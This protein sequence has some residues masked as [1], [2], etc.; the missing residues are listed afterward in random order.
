MI[1]RK[2]LCQYLNISCSL[3][4]PEFTAEKNVT[5]EPSNG[6]QII[7]TARSRGARLD[8]KIW[9]QVGQVDGLPN[10]SSWRVELWSRVKVAWEQEP[11]ITQAA[12]WVNKG[13]CK[14]HRQPTK[15]FEIFVKRMKVLEEPSKAEWERK[16]KQQSSH[17]FQGKFFSLHLPLLCMIE[18]YCKSRWLTFPDTKTQVLRWPSLVATVWNIWRKRLDLEKLKFTEEN[19]VFSTTSFLLPQLSR[20][21]KPNVEKPN[22]KRKTNILCLEIRNHNIYLQCDLKLNIP[23]WSPSKVLGNNSYIRVSWTLKTEQQNV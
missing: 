6:W 11:R 17:G 8:S 1:T 7:H 9:Q 21:K 18:F 12:I 23:I 10:Q 19:F 13:C 15:N 20:N 16:K 22:L 4:S 2:E 3:F 5:Q 14:M